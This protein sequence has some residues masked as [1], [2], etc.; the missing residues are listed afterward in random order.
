MKVNEASGY[1]W[2]EYMSFWFYE[3]NRNYADLWATYCMGG[4][5]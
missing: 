3:R 5:L 2:A 4:E 1:F